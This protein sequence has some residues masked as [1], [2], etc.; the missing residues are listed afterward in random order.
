VRRQTLLVGAEVSTPVLV[1]GNNGDR[2]TPIED[3]KA[4]SREIVRSR[5]VTVSA[6]GHG[7]YGTGNDC[8][9]AVVDGY[10]ARLEAPQDDFHCG[11]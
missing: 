11:A 4:L 2:T 7:A 10:L 5:F 3:T 1:I 6:E 8:A 9:D